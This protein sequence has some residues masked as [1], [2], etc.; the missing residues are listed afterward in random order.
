M[1]ITQAVKQSVVPGHRTEYNGESA[2]L[3]D[4]AKAR[5]YHLAMPCAIG[6]GQALI[7]GQLDM[8]SSRAQYHIQM[9]TRLER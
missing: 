4:I 3:M 1:L 8:F 7:P 5:Y 6:S 9:L 2:F